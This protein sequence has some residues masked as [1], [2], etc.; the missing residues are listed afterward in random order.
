MLGDS[1]TTDHISPAGSIA[2]NSPAGEYLTEHGVETSGLQQLRRPARQ[3]RGD[4]PWDLCQRAPA[5]PDRPGTEGGVTLHQPGGETMTIYDAAMSY[6]AG[7]H[8]ARGGSPARS[9]ARA[10]RA[11][12]PRRARGCWACARSLAESYERIHRSNLVGMGVLPLQFPPGQTRETLALTGEETYDIAGSR[13]LE[14]RR[15]STV[16]AT[17]REGA[18]RRFRLCASIR[19]TRSGTIIRRHPAFRVAE[20]RSRMRPV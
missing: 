8:A 10:R 12:G 17:G 1:V 20:A 6:H 15:R 7:R 3:P 14:P 18:S 5:Q 9:T 4:D 19:R 11:T 2:A 13:R 16:K